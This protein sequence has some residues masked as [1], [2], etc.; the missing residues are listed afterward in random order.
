MP[1]FIRISVLLFKTFTIYCCIDEKPNKLCQYIGQISIYSKLVPNCRRDR[2]I[3]YVTASSLC[4]EVQIFYFDFATFLLFIIIMPSETTTINAEIS[5]DM[6]I[7]VPH[8]NN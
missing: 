6:G 8:K 4:K 1:I 5:W 3:M 7:E 2:N